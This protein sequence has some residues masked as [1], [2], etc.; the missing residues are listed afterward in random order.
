M[1]DDFELIDVGGAVVV[2][3]LLASVVVIVVAAPEVSQRAEPPDSEWSIEMVNDS[4]MRISHEGGEPVDPGNLT[5]IVEEYPRQTEWLK[6]GSVTDGFLTE[7]SHA[8]IEVSDGQAV[9]LYWSGSEDT[10][11]REI[12]AEGEA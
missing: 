4:H 2:L 11:K 8:F 5:I 10:I 12:L 3:L 6:N 7:G 1:F 9:A